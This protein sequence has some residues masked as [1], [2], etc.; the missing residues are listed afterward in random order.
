MNVYTNEQASIS[1]VVLG[2]GLLDFWD[3]FLATNSFYGGVSMCGKLGREGAGC[4]EVTSALAGHL[5]GRWSSAGCGGRR[6]CSNVFPNT[7]AA[8]V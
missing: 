2:V 6:C 3:I 5:R 7:S 1:R 4:D 8:S